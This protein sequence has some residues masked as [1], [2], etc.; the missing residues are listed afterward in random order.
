MAKLAQRLPAAGL[1]A[2]RGLHCK[3]AARRSYSC[4]VPI[5]SRR[6][7][8]RLCTVRSLQERPVSLSLFFFFPGR[9]FYSP[10]QLTL[11]CACAVAIFPT[12]I[13]ECPRSGITT[14]TRIGQAGP[15]LC[16]IPQ[17]CHILACCYTPCG[18][19]SMWSSYMVIWV[20]GQTLLIAHSKVHFYLVRMWCKTNTSDHLIIRNCTLPLRSMYKQENMHE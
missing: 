12:F 2:I 3:A 4:M 17:Q 13:E 19:A 9:T 5:M 7:S 10:A 11:A 15:P 20:I 18:A 14:A 8:R 16:E 1:A 6:L